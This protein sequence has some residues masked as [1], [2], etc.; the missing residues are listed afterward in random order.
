MRPVAVIDID[1]TI[2]KVGDRLKY[3]QQT[4]KDWDNFYDACFDDEPIRETCDLVTALSLN[5]NIVFC[6]G[7]S[8]RVRNKTEEWLD[9]FLPCFRV[10]VDNAT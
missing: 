9:E 10:C 6:T 2:S 4:P 7:R 8:E 1:G 3:L 5:C